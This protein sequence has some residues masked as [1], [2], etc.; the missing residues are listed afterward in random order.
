MVP[1]DI[2]KKLSVSHVIYEFKILVEMLKFIIGMVKPCRILYQ[3]I[4]NINFKTH[5]WLGELLNLTNL[6]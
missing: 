6:N 2:F 1:T 3:F 4:F 5:I